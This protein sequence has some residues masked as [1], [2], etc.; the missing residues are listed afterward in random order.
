MPI[1]L[2]RIDDR[3]VHGQVT[4]GWTRAYKINMIVVVDDKIATDNIQTS[5][6][7]MTA[8]PGI[9]VTAQTIDAF[10]EEYKKGYYNKPRTMLIFTNPEGIVK[11]VEN[12]VPISSVNTGGMRFET[13]KTRISKAISVDEKDIQNFKKLIDMNIE[14]ECRMMP[15]EPMVKIETLLSKGVK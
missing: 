14:V 7:K 2:T 10:I 9:K 1:V 4:V 5:I 11:V 3:L 13:G 15:S 6:L 8:P 12:G